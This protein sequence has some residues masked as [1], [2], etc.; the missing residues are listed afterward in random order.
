MAEEEVKVQR[1][2]KVPIS[3][4]DNRFLS[5][6]NDRIRKSYVARLKALHSTLLEKLRRGTA[7]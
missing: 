1:F 7:I 6:L 2:S 3:D 4:K 5:T